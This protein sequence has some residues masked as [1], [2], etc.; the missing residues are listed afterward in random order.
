MAEDGA[1]PL[2]NSTAK[3]ATIKATYKEKISIAKLQNGIEQGADEAPDDDY[4]SCRY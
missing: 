1:E 2:T 4:I 3:V